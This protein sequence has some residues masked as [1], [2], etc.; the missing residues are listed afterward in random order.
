MN[1]KLLFAFISVGLLVG[2]AIWK[3]TK[4]GSSK[5]TNKYIKD[6]D[7]S[8]DSMDIPT[9]YIPEV[10]EFNLNEIKME[11]AGL[12]YDRHKEAAQV[13][14]ES[15]V[16]MTEET[17]LSSDNKMEFDSMFKDLDI[18]SEEE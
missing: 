3:L 5:S 11:S 6:T 7:N 12:M 17:D 4:Q 9:E 16:R 8:S 10:S 2:V 1:K 14:K 15:V 18:L 13:I